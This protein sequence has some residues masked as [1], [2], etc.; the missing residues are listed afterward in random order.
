MNKNAF[1][2]L[3]SLPNKA[4]VPK[5]VIKP[6]KEKRRDSEQQ[7]AFWIDK[8]LLKQLKLKAIE[9]NT[10]VKELIKRGIELVL[11]QSS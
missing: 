8:D 9:E 2:K 11:A 1:D 3:K 10:N 6:I 7:F 4:N 5:Q